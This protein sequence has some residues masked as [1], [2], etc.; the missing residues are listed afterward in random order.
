MSK[1]SASSTPSMTNRVGLKR[2]IDSPVS[3]SDRSPYPGTGS[4]HDL[5]SPLPYV[6]ASPSPIGPAYTVSE[7]DMV[8]W[9]R[10]Y[11]LSSSTGGTGF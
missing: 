4:E 1:R 10:K 7:D 3:R 9:R 2:R 8:E 11:S 5:A 6:Y